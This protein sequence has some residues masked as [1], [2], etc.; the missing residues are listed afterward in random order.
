[1]RREIDA[2]K[3]ELDSLKGVRRH[4]EDYHPP[5]GNQHS[6]Q[7]ENL[8]VSVSNSCSTFHFL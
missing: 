2:I 3:N 4:P 6:E 1:M 5:Q 7:V 8:Q